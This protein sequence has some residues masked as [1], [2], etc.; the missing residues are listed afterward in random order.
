ML[1]SLKERSD[2]A[3]DDSQN[4]VGEQTAAPNVSRGGTIARSAHYT[5]TLRQLTAAHFVPF[6]LLEAVAEDACTPQTAFH[7]VC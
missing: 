1:N 6:S 3:F 7:L 5:S 2:C 4:A